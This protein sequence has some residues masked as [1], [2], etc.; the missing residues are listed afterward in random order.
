MT[1]N[2]QE[3][4]DTPLFGYMNPAKNTAV[5]QTFSD[6]SFSPKSSVHDRLR[7]G[8][9]TRPLLGFSYYSAPLETT[10]PSRASKN[11]SDHLPKTVF[12]GRTFKHQGRLY[13]PKRNMKPEK[14]MVGTYPCQE[15]KKW[16]ENL[17]FLEISPSII[18]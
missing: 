18:T 16:H 1:S 5:R 9:L 8:L 12:Q 14:Q 17:D 11:K 2:H 3:T 4:G 15:V 6:A 13:R 7:W 10:L